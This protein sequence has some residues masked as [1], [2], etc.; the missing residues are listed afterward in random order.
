[1]AGATGNIY[2][3]L[4]EF[5]DMGFLLHFLRSED[6]F[7][8]IGSNI[9]SYTILASGQV[10]AKTFAF[11][12]VPSTFSALHKNILANNLESIVRAFK[13]IA[14]INGFNWELNLMH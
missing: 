10:G 13:T 7:F 1:M 5:P 4:H 2:M 12:P 8:D 14:C 11:E 9:G 3:G 6:L